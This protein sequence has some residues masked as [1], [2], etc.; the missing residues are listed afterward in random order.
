M[1]HDGHAEVEDHAL[2]GVRHEELPAAVDHGSHEEHDDEDED[3]RVEV[4]GI[5]QADV[6]HPLHHLRP[7]EAERG[8]DDEQRRRDHEVPAVRSDEPKEPAVH[9]DRGA[10]LLAFAPHA[11]HE[12]VTAAAEEHHRLRNT[13]ANDSVPLAPGA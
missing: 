6:Q 12:H 1:S 13:I 8:R 3:E 2:A 10:L 5:A 11:E 4:A 7:D 9:R